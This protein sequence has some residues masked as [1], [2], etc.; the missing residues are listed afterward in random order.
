MVYA[1]T[2]RAQAP[3]ANSVSPGLES[4]SFSLAFAIAAAIAATDTVGVA[5]GILL[6]QTTMN[7]TA[8]IEGPL[9]I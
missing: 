7:L 1:L 2:S 4:F 3:T 9:V 6:H 8:K 5:A